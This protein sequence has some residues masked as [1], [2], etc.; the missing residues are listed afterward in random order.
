MR[1]AFLGCINSEKQL[2]RGIFDD[3]FKFTL[4]QDGVCILAFSP[5]LQVQIL[6]LHLSHGLLRK[7]R[8]HILCNFKSSQ[9]TSLMRMFQGVRH[10]LHPPVNAETLWIKPDITRII[11]IRNVEK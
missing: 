7:P 9:M 1:A 11:T 4:R 3:Y 2:P 10:H 5:E 6:L 8:D